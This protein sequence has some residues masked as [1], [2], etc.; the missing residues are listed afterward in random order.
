MYRKKRRVGKEE[1]VTESVKGKKEKNK[2]S[3]NDD[4]EPSAIFFCA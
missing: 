1:K 4:R 3:L 2:C